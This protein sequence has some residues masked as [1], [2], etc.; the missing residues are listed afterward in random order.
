MTGA[1]YEELE[2][3]QK[4]ENRFWQGHTICNE[5]AEVTS[6]FCSAGRVPLKFAAGVAVAGTES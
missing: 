4:K 2:T 3:A 5:E 6:G 1:K